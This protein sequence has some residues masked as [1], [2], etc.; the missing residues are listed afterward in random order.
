MTWKIVEYT[1]RKKRFRNHKKKSGNDREWNKMQIARLSFPSGSV[2][3]LRKQLR[4]CLPFQLASPLFRRHPFLPSLAIPPRSSPARSAPAFPKRVGAPASPSGTWSS[5]FRWSVW[6]W[7]W[8]IRCPRPPSARGTG[9][10]RFRRRSRPPERRREWR[11]F[12]HAGLE[13]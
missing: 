5:S 9:E 1:L 4:N 6:W 8:R 12:L 10:L 11:G 3:F 2:F 7:R 13:W